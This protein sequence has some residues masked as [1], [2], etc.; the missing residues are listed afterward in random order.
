MDISQYVRRAV[1]AGAVAAV[2][3]TG[4]AVPTAWAQPGGIVI[5]EIHYHAGSDLDTDDFLE[6]A[7][8]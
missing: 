8:T 6:L 1:G 3:A 5:S 2:I 7:N 4:L